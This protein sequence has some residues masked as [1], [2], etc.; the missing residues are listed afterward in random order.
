MKN[1][2][3]VFLLEKEEQKIGNFLTN[4][5]GNQIKEKLQCKRKLI[6]LMLLGILFLFVI[7]NAAALG[8]TPGRTTIDFS[9]GLEKEIKFDILNSENKNM[10]VA[11]AVQSETEDEK[12]ISLDNNVAH[13]NSEENSKTFSYK[14]KLPSDMS[15]GLHRLGISAIELPEDLDSEEITV[16]TAISVVTQL[17]IYVKYPGKYLDANLDIIDEEKTNIV[18]FY[19]PVISRGE[20]NIEQVGGII[21]IYQGDK[22]I[23]NIGTNKL[24]IL[25]GERKELKAVLDSGE[26]SPGI[27]KA[28]IMIDYDGNKL[29]IEKEFEVGEEFIKVLGVS[30]DD[31]QLGEVARIK[32]LVQNK[33]GNKITKANAEMN[34]YD[35]ELR[36]VVDL[37]SEDYEIPE[38]SNKELIIYW[39]TK[40]TE[41]GKYTSEL[42]VNH[43]EKI[44]IKNLKIDISKNSMIFSGVGFA[45]SNNAGELN[46][47]NLL[48]IVIGILV[49]ANLLWF[50]WWLNKSKTKKKIKLNTY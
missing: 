19:I 30:A 28:K 41:Q 18:S 43:D 16:R 2:K 45:I 46:I 10:N 29:A 9:P 15:P 12:I 21:E 27:Y 6:M 32:I 3:W 33:Q 50:L 48:L 20:E 24:S 8:I 31:F 40:D 1:K 47:K 11:F 35:S 39:D 25:S 44:S 26:F 37:K 13:F 14:I 4:L 49:L 5:T 7:P 22:K 17:Y 34:V 23:K 42:K 38:L 36:Q